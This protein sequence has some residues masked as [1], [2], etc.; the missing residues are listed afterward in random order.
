MSA[1]HLRS[2]QVSAVKQLLSN[3]PEG[4]NRHELQALLGKDA[5]PKQLVA[6]LSTMKSAGVVRAQRAAGGVRYVLATENLLQPAVHTRVRHITPAEADHARFRAAGIGL[7][8]AIPPPATPVGITE[9]V[10]QWM[11]RTGKRP[12]VLPHNFDAPRARFPARRPTFT[13]KGH[14]A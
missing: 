9:T 6:T 13:P 5:N 12:E 7:H 14:A 3:K 8:A 4:H 11:T 10:E 2:R 1:V